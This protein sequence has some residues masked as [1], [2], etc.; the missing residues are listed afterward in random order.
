MVTGLLSILL[1]V[2]SIMVFDS[3]RTSN[4]EVYSQPVAGG[5]AT[6][7]TTDTAYDSFFA[8]QSPDGQSIVFTRTPKGV[9]DTDATK[10]SLWKMNADGSNLHQIIL[11]GGNGWQVQGHPEWLY[12]GSGLL[13]LGGLEI[14][15]Q[16]WR[17]DNE[18]HNPVQLTNRGGSNTDPK[19]HPTQTGVFVYSG[20]PQSVCYDYNH[21]IYRRYGSTDTRLTT[22]SLLDADPAYSPDGSRVAWLRRTSAT[23]W[24]VWVMQAN[25]TG[26]RSLTPDNA[27]SSRPEWSPDGQYIYFHR[28]NSP[29]WDIYRIKATGGGLTLITT[30]A[31]N[32]E[33]P[34]MPFKVR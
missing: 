7:L 2:A 9:H 3:D 21:E 10:N 33:Y 24:Q 26:K 12:D 6:R 8:R 34:S 23:V 4:Y 22:D 19:P 32:N 29:K 25:G 13:M 28:Y 30:G 11:V 5:T 20:C 16:I 1:A 31:G 27:I 15:P 14:S 18:G 17:T